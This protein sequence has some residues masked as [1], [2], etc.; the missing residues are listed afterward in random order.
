MNN[1]EIYI[2][3]GVL[4]IEPSSR[5]TLRC[6]QCPRTEH[7]DNIEL[8]DCDIESTVKLVKEKKHVIM[9]GNH[10]DAIYHPKFHELISSMRTSNPQLSIGMHTNGAF[11]SIDWW[12]KTASILD[13]RD[14][15]IFSIDGLPTNNHLYR[16]NSK[17]E[18]IENGIRT[19]VEHNP[20]IRIV[21]KW[22]LFKYNQHDIDEGIE[23]ARKLGF[24]G[25]RVV[26]SVRYEDD[27]PQTPSIDWK[28]IEKRYV[29]NLS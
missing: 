22:I 3:D 14:N 2:D 17:W 29:Q 18:S 23:L 4:H 27:D 28:E 24:H 15:I 13:H 11:R 10:G 7:I 8:E 1:E 25:F 12:K 26:N 5:C 16:V 21:W 6:P 19:L 20:D 9:C